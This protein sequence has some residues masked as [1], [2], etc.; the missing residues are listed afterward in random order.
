MS[1]TDA[2]VA[3]LGIPLTVAVVVWHLLRTQSTQHV[4]PSLQLWQH[5]ISEQ[6]SRK[7]ITWPVPWWLLLLR[8]LICVLLVFAAAGPVWASNDAQPSRII[9]IDASVSMQTRT[10]AGLRI[11]VA[12]QHADALIADA[13]V[14]TRFTVVVV[15]STLH[16]R[17]NQLQDRA[18]AH[19]VVAD[20]TATDVASDMRRM[21]PL[22]RQLDNQRSTL[23]I[24]SD[25]GAVWR[26]EG[27]PSTWQRVLVGG[28][29]NNQAIQGMVL[30]A[31]STGWQGVVRVTTHGT[32]T[33]PRL[34][35]LRDITGTLIDAT[36]VR[37]AANEAVEWQFQLAQPPDVLIA[38]LGEDAQDALLADDA[39][40]W[41]KPPTQAVRVFVQS[42]DTRFLPAALHVLPNIL[43]VN[44]LSD[45]DIAIIDSPA[46]FP[47]T[48]TVPTWLINP[49]IPT[50]VTFPM[51][52]P[53]V[54]R[55]DAALLTQD[56][57]MQQTQI[58][59]ASLLQTPLWAQ[60]WLQSAAGTHAYVGSNQGVAQVVLGMALTNSDLLLRADFPLLVR[61]VLRYLVPQTVSESLQTGQS[62]AL[63]ATVQDGEPV[64]L[65]QPAQSTAH[66]QRQQDTWYLVDILRP[67]AYRV[68]QQW[69]VA[70][71]LA[72]WESDVSRPAAQSPWS[73]WQQ[74]MALSGRM[75]SIWGAIIA[76]I[77]ERGL[78]WYT[79]RVT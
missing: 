64:L 62:L 53:V 49:P 52:Q 54:L 2:W 42:A 15:D 45:A 24:I 3:W 73:S 33:T 21:M 20:I 29:A 60:Q 38:K 31:T 70:N 6:T 72:P 58:I 28:D 66:I 68:D 11:D 55:G 26:D 16:I 19:Q 41:R 27:W 74:R 59:T 34:L 78:T 75:W 79:R 51:L 69:Y 35:E 5:V 8:A 65:A 47:T 23:Y 43:R 40:W 12:K 9:V 56:V 46:V 61:N 67:G 4:V 22:L 25:D 77:V 48:I 18:A 32:W 44:Q 57:D 71:I 37:A 10:T 36:Y 17:A 14:G 39:F 1:F 50:S 7:P 13:P 63:V 76:M 30:Q